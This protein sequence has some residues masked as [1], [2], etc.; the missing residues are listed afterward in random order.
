MNEFTVQLVSNV[1]LDEYPNNTLASFR[2]LLKDAVNL[3]GKWQVA[4]LEISFSPYIYNIR[5]SQYTMYTSTT[6]PSSGMPCIVPAGRYT[7]LSNI[8]QLMKNHVPVNNPL[9]WSFDVLS[10]KLSMTIPLKM[11]YVFNDDDLA[12]CLGLIPGKPYRAGVQKG[13]YSVDLTSGR[14][15][16]MVYTNIIEYGLV[17]DTKAPIL[18]AVPLVSKMKDDHDNMQITQSLHYRDFQKLQYKNLLTNNFHT[19]KMELRDTRGD[20]IPFMDCGR[21]FATLQFRQVEN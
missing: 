13:E 21:S 5:R 4:L 20:L 10:G 11:M 19:I 17:G 16:M 2:T 14:H 15:L 9:K 8:L 7:H 18:R 1:S 3:K 12:N 6:D